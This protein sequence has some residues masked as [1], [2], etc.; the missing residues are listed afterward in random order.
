MSFGFTLSIHAH[1]FLTIWARKS[2]LLRFW[3]K[4][5]DL[6]ILRN[7][8][9]LARFV[10]NCVHMNQICIFAFFI[11]PPLSGASPTWRWRQRWRQIQS[12][13]CRQ[14]RKPAT[15]ALHLFFGDYCIHSSSGPQQGDLLWSPYFFPKKYFLLAKISKMAKNGQ[16]S[17]DTEKP[18][19]TPR[20][21]A[22]EMQISAP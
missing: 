7:R 21:R 18:E 2:R 17:P 11:L 3:W 16:K 15:D 10:R 1:T 22:M 20:K 19:V 5:K 4:L 13:S 12:N 6:Q 14:W 9:F 8:D